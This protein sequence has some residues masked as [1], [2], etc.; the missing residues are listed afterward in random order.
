MLLLL[1]TD[2]AYI[3]QAHRYL[4]LLVTNQHAEIE[5]LGMACTA[6]PKSKIT[7]Q[8]MPLFLL[9]KYTNTASS[10]CYTLAVLIL[11]LIS[12]KTYCLGIAIRGKYIKLN[13]WRQ[14]MSWYLKIRYSISDPELNPV[15]NNNNNNNVYNSR[16]IVIIRRA[17]IQIGTQNLQQGNMLSITRAH[18]KHVLVH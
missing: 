12:N 10:G 5:I 2:Y 16:I 18:P 17:T 11:D 3:D 14:I 1:T 7:L 8:T 6:H 4:L 9:I 13:K 15:T